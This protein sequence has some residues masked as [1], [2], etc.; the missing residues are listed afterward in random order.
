MKLQQE[1]FEIIKS[2][3]EEGK[4][5]FIAL[6]EEETTGINF[7]KM[8]EE[9][10][11]NL[12]TSYINRTTEE[13]DKFNLQK[14]LDIYT[15]NSMC[16]HNLLNSLLEYYVGEELYRYIIENNRKYMF[17]QDYKGIMVL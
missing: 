4:K 8:K 16:I 7:L 9:S 3:L 14:F 15:E 12:F 6:D 5:V 10:Y 17:A 2:R 11:N 1:N 13:A